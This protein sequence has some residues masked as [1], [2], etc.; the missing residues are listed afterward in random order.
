[1]LSQWF[2]T[3]DVPLVLCMPYRH[4]AWLVGLSYLVA[5]F[6]AYTAFD[7]IG[8]VRAAETPLAR[9]FWL[10][11]AGLSMGFGIWAMH[12]IA[13]LAVEI[14]TQIRFDLWITALSAAFA[15]TASAIA[16]HIVADHPGDRVRLGVAGVVLGSGI[17]LMHYTGMA[18]LYMSARI[19]YDPTL[20]ALS[21]VVAVVFSTT[22]L[23]A[24][25]VMPKL[26]GR[27]LILARL[28]GSAVMGFAIVLM[29]YTGMFATVFYPRP[30][31][32]G[33]GGTVF[34]PPVMAVSIAFLSILIVGL[35][36]IAALCDR[37]I[38]R[39]EMLLRD[40]LASISEGFVIYDSDDRLVL[41]NEAY[42]RMYP[43]SAPLMVPGVKFE[44][45]VRN[46]LAAGHYPE[47]AGREEEWLAGF[48]RNHREAVSEVETQ[49]RD[50]RWILVSERRMSSGGIAGVRVDVTA[51]KEAQTALAG[52]EARLDRAQE[53]AGI[54]DWELDL[55]TRRYVWSKELYR[56]RGLS[57]ETFEPTF[58][59][60]AAYVHP[61]DLAGADRWLYDL[62][63]GADLEA[64]E[65]RIVRPDGEARV[66]RVEGQAV[67]DA[68]GV[69]RRVA[70]TMQDI[71][72]RKHIE[73]QLA[74]SQKMEAIGSLT[75]GMAHD[76]NNGLGVIIGNLDLLARM[77]Q[78]IGP[79]AEM[80]DEARQAATRCADL[81]RGLLAFARRQPLQSRQTDLNALVEGVTRLLGRT[82]GENIELRLALDGALWPVLADAA[83]LEA[84]VINLASNARDAM[85]KGGNIDVATRN[86]QLDAHY[87]VLHPEVVPGAYVLIEV[88]DTGEGIPP[89]ILGR[90]FEPFFTTKETGKGTGL[91]LSMVFG[92]VKQSGGHLDVYSEVGRGT[93]FR[94]YLPR[95]ETEEEPAEVPA[96][97]RPIV[98]GRETI[99]VVEDNAPLRRVAVQQL[100][101]LGYRVLEA[102][103][104]ELALRVISGPEAIDLV[105]TDVVMPGAMDGIEF[106]NIVA[107]LRSGPG[108]LLTSGFPSARTPSGT[109]GPRTTAT[110][111]PML[112]KPYRIDDLA[113]EVREA[114]DRRH[115]RWSGQDD[116]QTGRELT[117]GET[118]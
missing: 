31:L 110:G 114:L 69:I 64:Y 46:S 21:V 19:Y 109:S 71:T 90:V 104:A 13:M 16:F 23:F 12:F 44:A 36:M 84:A 42:R 73:R 97:G 33:A 67:R 98:G 76:F 111:F 116:G 10:I 55:A 9:F 95:A 62:T 89:E 2:L 50:G 45:L 118:V 3:S 1:M 7:L 80:C 117:L 107:R 82:L 43:H 32:P 15:A 22:A 63:K 25:S 61:D 79:A 112:G 4:D 100:T 52:S 83:Q 58:E 29:H 103:N 74:Q 93:T 101:E 92:F 35:T 37:R 99:L 39:A 54:G 26:K 86:V 51:L 14:R 68:D 8:R 20:F 27:G 113:H 96:Q 59:N 106:A 18:A 11:T 24:L 5:T 65:T 40:A 94:I 60:V 88:S 17:G 34:D 57:P 53:I 81:I 41:C 108:V 102:E 72:E 105:F 49:M 75:G 66:L 91:G 30:E 28:A 85:P 77:V 70:G 115:E 38:K 56:I 6:A 48:I 87:A 78:S 47:A